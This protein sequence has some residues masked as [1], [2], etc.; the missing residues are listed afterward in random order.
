MSPG[1]KS[2]RSQLNADKFPMYM[3]ITTCHPSFEKV[4][5]G[6]G[7]KTKLQRRKV[8]THVAIVI[9]SLTDVG[10]EFVLKVYFVLALYVFSLR[11]A[12]V[13]NEVECH[14][15]RLDDS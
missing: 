11:M 2:I 15:V 6:L 5:C 13:Y 14:F 8:G 12:V 4:F 7:L 3:Q 9:Q 1:A 10:A